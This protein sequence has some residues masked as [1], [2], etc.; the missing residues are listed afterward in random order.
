MMWGKWQMC[1]CVRVSRKWNMWKRKQRW[2][3]CSSVSRK[4]HLLSVLSHVM[5]CSIF[6]EKIFIHLGCLS[7]VSLY[8]QV[9]IF[10]E[11]KADVDAI[12]EYLLLKGVEAVAIHGGKGTGFYAEGYSVLH[13]K[14]LPQ[15]T[16]HVNGLSTCSWPS[17]SNLPPDVTLLTDVILFE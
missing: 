15:T 13:K 9:L 7:I 6:K 10:A 17:C 3:T 1:F 8:W 11:K 14:R 2:C 5:M 16:C 4:Q 12:H